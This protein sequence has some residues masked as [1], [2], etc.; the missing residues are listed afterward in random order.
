MAA[1]TRDSVRAVMAAW[2][3]VSVA[4]GARAATGV[5]AGRWAWQLGAALGPSPLAVAV[6]VAVACAVPP[7]SSPARVVVGGGATCGG[8]RVMGSVVGSAV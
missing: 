8:G 2:G 3:H 4:V 1:A 7:G 5:V 6:A